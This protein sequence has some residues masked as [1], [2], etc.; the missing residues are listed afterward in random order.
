MYLGF[1]LSLHFLRAGIWSNIV[2]LETV[3]I[4]D[5][6]LIPSKLCKSQAFDTSSEISQHY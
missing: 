2:N 5:L 6:G 4:S 3:S 1:L